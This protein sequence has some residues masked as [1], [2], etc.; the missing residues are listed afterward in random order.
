MDSNEESEMGDSDL[1]AAREGSGEEF[2]PLHGERRP[3]ARPIRVAHRW[4]DPLRSLE[5]DWKKGVGTYNF[6]WMSHLPNGHLIA[7][8]IL[9]DTGAQVN[10]IKEKTSGPSIFQKQ[11]KTMFG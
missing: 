3:R 5:T 4:L 9:V 6:Y 8:K 10:I 11:F 1:G 2:T 7:L